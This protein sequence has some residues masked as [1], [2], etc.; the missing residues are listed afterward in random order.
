MYKS[1]IPPTTNILKNATDLIS[2]PSILYFVITLYHVK[3]NFNLQRFEQI[4]HSFY[5]AKDQKSHLTSLFLIQ[6]FKYIRYYWLLIRF[7]SFY[8]FI[9]IFKHL[10]FNTNGQKNAII[11]ELRR[12]KLT[13]DLTGRYTCSEI[14]KNR[15]EQTTVHVFIYGSFVY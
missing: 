10:I 1:N 9:S 2:I 14:V 5:D 7:H 13:S 11:A 8:D 4:F 3:F 15:L 12:N 6:P